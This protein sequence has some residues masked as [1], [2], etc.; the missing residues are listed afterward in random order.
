MPGTNRRSSRWP[1]G[2]AAQH[3]YAGERMTANDQLGKLRALAMEKGYQLSPAP[4]SDCWFLVHNVTREIVVVE[5]KTALSAMRILDFL[6][7]ARARK[8][9]TR[10]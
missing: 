5:G 6:M 1:P 7:K 9:A 3:P 2:K 10:S 8:T 4:G